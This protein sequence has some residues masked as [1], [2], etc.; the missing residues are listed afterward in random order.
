MSRTIAPWRMPEIKKELP[1]TCKSSPYLAYFA[2]GVKKKKAPDGFM[3][4][5]CNA[6]IPMS[7]VVA[8]LNLSKDSIS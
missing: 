1:C 8:S 7:D 5:Q 2:G 6:F 4:M 3:C